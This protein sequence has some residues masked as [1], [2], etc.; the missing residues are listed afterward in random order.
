MCLK[1]IEYVDY[2]SYYRKEHGKKNAVGQDLAIVSCNILKCHL[3]YHISC[4]LDLDI[5]HLCS[6][7]TST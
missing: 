4:D 3:Q 1:F 6:K 7:F 2:Y 5:P